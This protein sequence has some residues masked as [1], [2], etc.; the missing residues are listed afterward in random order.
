MS[1]ERLSRPPLVFAGLPTRYRWPGAVPSLVSA[2][3]PQGRGRASAPAPLRDCF[4]RPDPYLPDRNNHRLAGGIQGQ[5]LGHHVGSNLNRAEATVDEVRVRFDLADPIGK[6]RPEITLR[7]YQLPFSQSVQHQ[8]ERRNDL[9]AIFDLSLPIL[10]EASARWVT[11]I[12]F[13]LHAHF[14]SAPDRA[15]PIQTDESEYHQ[16]GSGYHHPVRIFHRGEPRHFQM[17]VERPA[18]RLAASEISRYLEE[19]RRGPIWKF[20]S[21][22]F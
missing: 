22:G 3:Q 1:Q 6:N 17:A 2:L 8:G 16:D 20:A 9:Y 10:C 12:L 15:Q 7:A 19:V 21:G 5:F 18:G 11:F 14:P 4:T 13:T